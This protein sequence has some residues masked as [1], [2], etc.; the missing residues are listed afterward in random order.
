[1]RFVADLHIHSH[2]SISTS[3]EL[4]PESLDAWAR[5]KGIG[6]LGTGDATHPGWLVELVEK[7]QPAEEGLYRLKETGAA[8]PSET[9]SAAAAAATA[10]APRFLLSAEVSTIYRRGERTRK[11][12]HLIL[13]P[14]LEEALALAR[15]LERIGN[16]SSDGRPVLG[17]DSRNLLEIVLEAAPGACFI[18]AHIWTPWFSALGDKSGFDSIEECY[19]PLAA[20]IFAV[21]TGLS[22]DPPMN[23]ACGFL[24]RFALVSNSDA[25]S[26]EKL[27]REANLFD[28]ELSYPA[29]VGALKAAAEQSV[30]LQAAGSGQAF[31]PPRARDAPAAAVPAPGFLGTIEFFPQEGKYHYDGHRKCGVCWEPRRTLEQGGLCPV[32][33][34]PVTVGVMHRVAQLASR[35]PRSAGS[36]PAAGAAGA[37]SPPP[38]RPG[39]HSLVPLKEILAEL[40]GTGAQ[41]RK[42]AL[43]YEQLLARAGTELGVL[44][45]LPV[46]EVARLGGEDL[47][48]AVRR[49]RSGAVR[50]EPGYDGEYGRIRLFDPGE[51]RGRDLQGRGEQAFLFGSGSAGEPPP[52]RPEDSAGARSADSRQRVGADLAAYRRAARPS[53]PAEPAAPAQPPALAEPAA[54]AGPAAA[55]RAPAAGP[56]AG[57]AAGFATRELNAE[58]R[59]AVEHGDGPALVLAG[60][61]TGKTGVLAARIAHLTLGRGVPPERILAVTFTNRAAREMRERLARLLPDPL[62]RER[63]RVG[64]FHAFGLSLLK[65]YGEHLGLSWPFTILDPEEREQLVGKLPACPKGKEAAMAEAL[66]EVKQTPA[67][68]EEDRGEALAELLRQYEATLAMQNAVDLD[69][70]LRLPVRLLESQPAVLAQA[71]A[72]SPWL[73]IDEY[74][75]V[76]PVQYRLVRLL[77]PSPD[78]PLFAIGDPHQAIYGF[79]G[80]DPRFIG[81]FLEDYPRAAVYG[82]KTSYRCSSTIL[83]AS[84][85]VLAGG[86]GGAEGAEGAEAAERAEGPLSAARIALASDPAI[87]DLRL[88]LSEHGSEA[89]EAEFVARTIEDMMGGVRFFSLDSEVSGGE[90]ESGIRGFAD[91]AVLCRVARQMEPLAKALRDHSIPFQQASE[92]P[93]LRQESVRRIL[94]ILRTLRA[95]GSA[96]SRERALRDGLA[97][98]EDLESWRLAFEQDG[99]LDGLIRMVASA[100]PET[101]EGETPRRLLEA[102]AEAGGDID[103]FLEAAAL[104][105]ES[106]ALARGAES[107]SLLTLHAAKGLEFPCVFITGCEDGL[108]PCTLFGRRAADP[109]EERRLFYVGM[110]RARTH[111]FL[112]RAR[113]RQLFGRELRLPPSPFLAAVREELA[114][115]LRPEAE[116][117][118]P[119]RQLDLF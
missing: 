114:E 47:A 60:P 103:A 37:G 34:K 101:R 33:G 52:L 106:D 110:T 84:A 45:Q 100:F 68:A 41:S 12:H 86:A 16:L 31:L 92:A 119:V 48:E 64:T 4:V 105:S 117:A 26:P 116:R 63:V 88:R 18:P 102:A 115:R 74:Q 75:D 97:C 59:Q 30:M 62:A 93:W 113:R 94:R 28:A 66:S 111:L 1:M 81:R 69:D 89:S 78:S 85:G 35:E 108:L 107:V 17:L 112:S 39:F 99:S 23:W 5:R 21:E 10:A 49:M 20:H 71:R 95:P 24:D 3:R 73:L 58:Q 36:L 11:V 76:N 87:R 7:L 43:R 61:G 42:V 50:V 53:G 82:L 104:G 6:V 32:C 22:S 118:R 46:E 70:L 65:A 79:R 14:G 27:G 72:A 55:G 51:L 98:P 96:L 90:A 8:P 54:D 56:A 77:L 19:G 57:L 83:Q 2:Y 40:A 80:A 67:G 29:I 15:R 9:A 109:E 38:G 13:L 91:F 44:M 25:H